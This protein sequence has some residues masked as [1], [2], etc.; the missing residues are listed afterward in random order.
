M[1][2]YASIDD[3]AMLCI[4]R[5]LVD[6]HIYKTQDGSTLLHLT[7]ND[8]NGIF[9]D[10]KRLIHYLLAECYCDPNCLDSK[11]QMPL[12]LTSDPRIMKTL[13]EHNAKVTTD[14]VFKVVKCVTDSRAMELLNLSTR[15]GT[16]LWNPTDLNSDGDTAIHLAFKLDKPA[17]INCLLTE[18][19]CDPN[20]NNHLESLLELTT[21]L[22][23]AKIL[24]KHGARATPASVL[25]FEAMEA[26]ETKPE[27]IKLMITTWNCDDRN[28]DGFTALHLACKA[29]SPTSVNLLLSVAH[30]DPNIKSNDEL[31]PLQMTTNA[32]I[33]KDLIRHGAKTSIMYESYERSLG[34]NKPVQP[35]VKVFIVG[36]PSV[37]KSTL[38][39]A[40]KTKIG[41]IARI[42]SGKVSGV[43]KKTVGIVPHDIE[44][45][46]FGRVTL[47]DFA[48]HRE[49]YSGHAALLQTAIQSTPPIFLLVVDL[50]ELIDDIIEKIL[51]WTVFL[52]N[53]CAS[54]SCKPH[55]IL[56]GSHADTL[57]GVNLRDK[58][59]T[60]V[61]SLDTKKYFTN[62]EYIGFVAMNCQY[63]ESPGMS[64][65]RCLL[66]NSCQKLRIH[67]P[68][69][70][71]AHCF[72]VFLIDVFM[73]LT[74]VSI[75]TISKRIEISNQKKVY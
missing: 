61:K 17:I 20:A 74:A 24:I 45:D 23:I 41:F 4:L 28:S 14:V 39:A 9:R 65:L 51:Y 5:S 32:E 56:V 19:K 66:I 54:V 34:T 38:T 1:N 40:L 49:F 67:E 53:Q 29:D 16:M 73:N 62:M 57:K 27:L 8:V 7:C 3:K 71:N 10:R 43:D 59:E 22:E 18:V 36:N 47:Y 15:K 55:I 63:H 11:G 60:I 26:P 46:V 33:I 75:K 30:C 68:I 52:E 37:G 48:G 6:N 44:S 58:V 12:Q 2:N 13:V 50:R 25:R 21:N 31:V 35:P 72:L 64:D 69:T 42:F 70:F